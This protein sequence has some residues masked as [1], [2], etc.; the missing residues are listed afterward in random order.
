M[1]TKKN[2]VNANLE[3]RLMVVTKKNFDLDCY[4]FADHHCI[5]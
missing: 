5:F 4:Q 3:A 1:K 2:R